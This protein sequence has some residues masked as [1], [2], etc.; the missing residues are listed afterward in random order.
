METIPSFA[1]L[2]ARLA[3][4]AAA[5]RPVD[6]APDDWSK[7][8]ALVVCALLDML[9]CVCAAL[10]ARAAAGLRPVTVPAM[11]YNTAV[12]EFTPRMGRQELPGE[13]PARLLTLALG[14]CAVALEPATAPTG[15]AEPT[16]AGPWLAWSRD[17]GPLRSIPASPGRPRRETGL[18]CSR[19]RTSRMLRCNN[20]MT[21]AMTGLISD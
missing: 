9:I 4:H 12:A 19:L 7:V 5:I 21:L 8:A 16:P 10:D 13:R 11:G 20:D 3:G 14:A 2:A 17:R 6:G 15:I 18:F 1:P